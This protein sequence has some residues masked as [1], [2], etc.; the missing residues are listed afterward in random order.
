MSIRRLRQT[1][2]Y[3]TVIL[4]TLVAMFLFQR[5][6]Q[7]KGLRQIAAQVTTICNLPEIPREITIRHATIDRSEDRQFVDVILALSGPT[8]TL[9]T[10]LEKIDEWEKKRP[11]VIQNHKIR[12]AE[13]SS[14]VDFSAEVYLK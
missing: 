11:G 4:A 2:T 3:L 9:D 7:Q 5:F 14:R 10:W 8:K 1:L 12:E 6:Q 13:M